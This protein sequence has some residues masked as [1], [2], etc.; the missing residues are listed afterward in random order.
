VSTSTSGAG[1][2]L[3]AL[4]LFAPFFVVADRLTVLL[5]H[6]VSSSV[7]V[8]IVNAAG[9]LRSSDGVERGVRGVDRLMGVVC[10]VWKSSRGVWI[11]MRKVTWKR[12][13]E[14]RLLYLFLMYC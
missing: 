11:E 8:D 5:I 12:E 7:F 9:V 1:G 10:G 2:L 13:K 4:L 14:V 3:P 6:F